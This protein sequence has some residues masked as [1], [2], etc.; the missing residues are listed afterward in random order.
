MLN[1]KNTDLFKSKLIYHLAEVFALPFMFL[2]AK[3]AST[4]TFESKKKY[5]Q[6]AIKRYQTKLEMEAFLLFTGHNF[7]EVLSVFL[8]II[9]IFF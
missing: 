8:I 1:P 6:N 3:E 9:F 2:E 5:F 4:L 7:N